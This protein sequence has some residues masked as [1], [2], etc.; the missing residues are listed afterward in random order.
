MWWVGSVSGLRVS[1]RRGLFVPDTQTGTSKTSQAFLKYKMSA[2]CICGQHS[3]N[4]AAVHSVFVKNKVC[5]LVDS[6]P[7]RNK[8]CMV[9]A[10]VS[11]SDEGRDMAAIS[12]GEVPNNLWSGNVRMGKP[13]C[14]RQESLYEDAYLGKWN[15]SVPRGKESNK[16]K[17]LFGRMLSI[18]P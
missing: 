12:F 11:R 1:L 17:F 10:L 15:I 3:K 5:L 4:C 2:V 16:R 6:V 7:Y 18:S 8:G 13:S 9:N 14:H